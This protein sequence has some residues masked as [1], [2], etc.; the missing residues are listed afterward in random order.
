MPTSTA[1]LT[2]LM[3]VKDEA[4]EAMKRF[5]DSMGGAG[6]YSKELG[7]GLLAGGAAAAGFGALAVKAAA[8]AQA[9]MANFETALQNTSGATQEARDRILEAAQAAAKLGFDDEAAAVAMAQLYQRTG[10]VNQA[11]NLNSIAMDLARAKHMGLEEASSA[12]GLVLSGNGKL[13]K[14]YGINLQ[15]TGTPIDA[16]IELQGKL[17]D[18]AKNYG[19]TFNGQMEVLKVQVGNLMEAIGDS[20]LL[21][22][23]TE[24]IKKINDFASNELPVWIDKSKEIYGWLVNHKE[25][26]MIVTG[27]IL[28]ALIPAF[29]LLVTVTLPAVI[30]GFATAAIALAPFMLAGVIIVGIG[31]GIK[32]VMDHWDLIKV[33]TFEVFGAMR[34]YLTD[35]WNGIVKTIESA[36]NSILNKLQPLFDAVNK[37]KSAASGIVG[38][39][40][41]A[42]NNASNWIGSNIPKFAAGGIVT[43]PTFAMVGEAGPE[44]IIPLN[45]MGAGMGG[46]VVN[47]YGGTY[48]SESVAEEIG[49]MIID[50]L[51]LQLRF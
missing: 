43:S 44:A 12:V 20:G 9:E 28:G 49:D 24:L 32:Y 41:G 22:A 11:I 18:S 30:A 36:V 40:S 38:S 39:A 34:T 6:K 23:M 4:T 29:V 3:K 15:E 31:L 7:V 37:A 10:D 13:L 25:I 14:Y 48:L 26:L 35:T 2:I 46:V 5:S 17:K 1:E 33:K 21:G 16:L 42:I 27:A 19:E 50:K 45:K 47:I 8:D 51:K